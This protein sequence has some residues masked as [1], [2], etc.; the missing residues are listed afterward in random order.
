MIFRENKTKK[1][2]NK[3]NMYKQLSTDISDKKVL[4]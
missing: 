4:L 2:L 1:Q 3:N